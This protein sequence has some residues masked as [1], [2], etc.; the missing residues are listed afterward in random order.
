M[1]SN[2][3]R[4]FRA[5]LAWAVLALAM[6]VPVAAATLSPL[7]AWRGPIYILAGFAGVVAMS[8]L[9]VQPLLAAGVLPGLEGRRG[10]RLHRWVGGSIV[11]LV[12]LHVAALWV[13]SPPDVIDVLLFTS[14]TPFSVWGVTAMWALFLVAAL[15]LIRRK[16]WAWHVIHRGLAIVVVVGSV[17]H[18][19]LIVGTMEPVTKAILCL[20]V[21][22]A[23]LAVTGLVR[24]RA[25][26]RPV[27]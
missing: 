16:V 25:R 7:L 21:V 6:L 18:A 22:A 20:M 14:P 13:T 23:T 11:T 26:R 12:V 24:I 3:G 2:Q 5:G 8:L 4:R 17:I 9:L 19:V 15:A 1:P 10:R 27:R